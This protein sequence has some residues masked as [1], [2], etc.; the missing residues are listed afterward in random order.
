MSFSDA[1]QLQALFGEEDDKEMYH[2]G[3]SEEVVAFSS[4]SAFWL[5]IKLL[6]ARSRDRFCIRTLKVVLVCVLLFLLLVCFISHFDRSNNYE[7]HPRCL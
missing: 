3:T 6:R 4:S 1:N 2:E 5:F 7:L